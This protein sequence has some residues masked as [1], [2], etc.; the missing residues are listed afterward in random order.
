MAN[1][2]LGFVNSAIPMQKTVE[3]ANP[4]HARVDVAKQSGTQRPLHGI[5]VRAG[6]D[7]SKTTGAFYLFP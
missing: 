2:I 5:L 3:A 1:R 4:A 6:F 7:M